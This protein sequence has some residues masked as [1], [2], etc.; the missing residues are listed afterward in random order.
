MP[1]VCFVFVASTQVKCVFY[2]CQILCL[3]LFVCFVCGVLLRP[4]SFLYS[5]RWANAVLLFSWLI[6]SFLVCYALFVCMNDMLIAATDILF[7]HSFT[8]H[9]SFFVNTL[10]HTHTHT[11][12]GNHF[13]AHLYT[14]C[15][16]SHARK[17][18]F[19]QLNTKQWAMTS[20]FP[21][22]KFT[23]ATDPT[24]ANTRTTTISVCTTS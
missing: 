23:Y 11:H 8:T 14:H 7:T 10:L 19:V 2:F 9:L 22:V 18:L 13:A 12:T 17:Q 24:N 1:L 3:T 15:S 21:S 5:F 6:L 20:C 16:I 4:L